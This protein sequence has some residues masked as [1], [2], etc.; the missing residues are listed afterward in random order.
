MV[1]ATAGCRI[2]LFGVKR[3]TAKKRA[4]SESLPSHLSGF[5]ILGQLSTRC[6]SNDA[7]GGGNKPGARRTSSMKV[8]HNNN[9]HSTDM[10]ESIRIHTGYSRIRN[11]DSRNTRPEIQ[12][13]FRPKPERQNAARERKS[14]HLPSMQ[15][16]EAFSCIFPSSLLFCEGWKPL[17]GILWTLYD[18]TSP[19]E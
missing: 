15:S 8:P 7:D 17:P 10:V 9:H 5:Y 19:S 11:P 14:I 3:V 13:Q 16:G 6:G 1:A 12:P 4:G 2:R 18:Y